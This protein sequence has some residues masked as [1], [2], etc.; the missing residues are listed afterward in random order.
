MYFLVI[1]SGVIENI[2][3]DNTSSLAP[4]LLFLKGWRIR[5]M[6]ISLLTLVVSQFIS[7]NPAFDMYVNEKLVFSKHLEGRYPSESVFVLKCCND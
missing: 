4:L 1:I 5:F 7:A 6:F 3:I 2:K